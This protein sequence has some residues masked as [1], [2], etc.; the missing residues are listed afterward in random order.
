MSVAAP[1]AL[2]LVEEVDRL[3]V[4]RELEILDTEPEQAFDEIVIL[5]ANI[6]RVPTS[7]VSLIDEDRQWFKARIG[8]PVCETSRDVSF[9][10]HI[11]PGKRPLVVEDARL[12]PRFLSNPLVLTGQVIFYAGVPL[13]LPGGQVLGSLCVIDQEPRQIS[14]QTMGAL[15]VLGRQVVDQMML[16]RANRDLQRQLRIAESLERLS[17]FLVR[18]NTIPA[19]LDF[20]AA[21]VQKITDA[22]SCG[23]KFGRRTGPTESSWIGDS[24]G[25]EA[26][27]DLEVPTD[28]SSEKPV[29]TLVRIKVPF[30]DPRMYGFVLVK[31]SKETIIGPAHEIALRSLSASLAAAIERAELLKEIQLENE[32]RRL[33]E[34]VLSGQAAALEGLATGQPLPEI[35]AGLLTCYEDIDPD[36]LCLSTRSEW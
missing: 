26:E 22:K 34:K 19:I 35:M 32:Q 4:L 31:T 23:V 11:L 17:Q 29:G 1:F 16:R 28:F 25:E 21:E 8:M 27:S 30:E 6:A 7:L 2:T 36:S 14:E 12:D 20:A 15:E 3:R 13:T 24:S 9:C 18:E 5:A 10:Q 33:G